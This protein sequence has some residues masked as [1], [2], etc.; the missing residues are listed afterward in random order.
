M[1]KQNRYSSGTPCSL[2]HRAIVLAL[3]ICPGVALCQNFE[4]RD[5]VISDYHLDD[6]GVADVDGDGTLDIFTTNH[7]GQQFLSFGNGDGTFT[8]VD[9]ESLGIVQSPAIPGLPDSNWKPDMSEEGFYIYTRR[10]SIFLKRVGLA[11][12]GKISGSLFHSSTR[13]IR[14]FNFYYEGVCDGD[15]IYRCHTDFE[16]SRKGVMWFGFSIYQNPKHISLDPTIP[17]DK[18]FIGTHRINPDSHEIRLRL[19]DRHGMAWSDLNGDGQLDAYINSGG[20]HG[21]LEQIQDKHPDIDYNNELFCSD[22]GFFNPCIEGSGLFKIDDRGRGSA[23]VDFNRDGLLDLFVGNHETVNRLYKQRPDGTFVDR[24]P[25]FGLD[26]V[27]SGP[28]VWFDVDNDRDSDLLIVDKPNIVLFRRIPGGY[29]REEIG[30][31][32]GSYTTWGY[33][34]VSLF[35]LDGDKYLD[36]LFAGATGSSVV[37]NDKGNLSTFP[38][39]DIGLPD[40]SFALDF[41]DIDN[42]G[43]VEVHVV[44]RRC[45][46]D[47]IFVLNGAMNFERSGLLS[48]LRGDYCKTTRSFWF[49][50]DNNGFRDLLISQTTDAESQRLWQTRLLS[51]E[52]N[53]NH[54]LQVELRG[55]AGNS[56][57]IG[58]RVLVSGGGKQHVRQVGQFEGSRYSQGHYRMYFGLGSTANITRLKVFWPDGSNTLMFDVKPDR[59]ITISHGAMQ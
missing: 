42:D 36:A 21:L 27:D 32:R 50:A 57:A 34:K 37:L 17:L 6:H 28:F 14:A 24:A 55:P 47:G 41:V 1:L 15:P 22:E 48:D 25:A 5:L 46:E 4:S 39:E 16:N 19:M 2:I 35:D 43:E 23:W 8:A 29:N 20:S 3:V 52:G 40:K 45:D 10:G 7:N 49:D 18:I 44:S 59:L 13:E 30:P 38:A 11:D 53:A 56:E 54:W 12:F 33:G 51:N 9:V 31:Y 26:I 58:A